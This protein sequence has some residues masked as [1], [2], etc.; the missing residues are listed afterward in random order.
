MSM[1]ISSG[2]ADRKDFAIKPVKLS[3][4]TQSESKS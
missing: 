3:Y 4:F 2:M 1:E